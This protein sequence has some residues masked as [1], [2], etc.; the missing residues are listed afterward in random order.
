[1]ITEYILIGF[2]SFVVLAEQVLLSRLLAIKYWSCFASMVVSIAMLGFAASGTL[3]SLFSERNN[4]FNSYRGL[5]FAFIGL[6]IPLSVQVIYKTHCSPLAIFWEGR[7]IGIF[8]LNYIIMALP[9]LLTGLFLGSSYT[10]RDLSVKGVYF[11]SMI[12]SCIAV[13][14]VILL[15]NF[16]QPYRL[17]LL[18]SFPILFIAWLLERRFITRM[19]IIGLLI[20][21]F[22]QMFDV[23]EIPP[24]SEYKTMS[25]FMLLP[26]ARVEHTAWS[27]HGYTT[28]VASRFIRYAP[29]LSLNFIG[30]CPEQKAIFTDGESMRVIYSASHREYVRNILQFQLETLPYLLVSEPIVAMVDAGP[31]GVQNAIELG[32]QKIY[33]LERNPDIIKLVKHLNPF[34]GSV[35]SHPHVRLVYQTPRTFFER[36]HGEFDLVFLP[37]PPSG[38]ANLYGSSGHDADYMLTVEAFY[39]YFSSLSACGLIAV[40]ASLNLPP[41]EEMKL[42]TTACSALRLHGLN[43]AQHVFFVRSLRNCLLMVSRTPF[44]EEQI[45]S[46]ISFCKRN[47]FDIIYCYGIKR[48]ETN[49]FNILPDFTHFEMVRDFLHERPDVWHGQVFNLRPPTDNRPFFSHFFRW[50][51]LPLLVLAT[52]CNVAGQIGWG[53]VFLLI[54]LVQAIVIGLIFVLI[55]LLQYFIKYRRLLLKL[56]QTNL[57]FMAIGTGFMVFEIAVFQQIFRFVKS[58]IYAF[59]TGLVLILMF[60]GLGSLFA[61]RLR[62]NPRIKVGITA[63]ALFIHS[64]L[65]FLTI[66]WHNSALII[67]TVCSGICSA[68]LMGMPFPLGLEVL[69]QTNPK[70]IPLAWGLNGYMSVIA[71]L[72]ASIIAPCIGI[73]ELC[74]IAGISYIIASFCALQNPVSETVL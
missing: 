10:N 31:A 6:V 44:S 33:V 55:P 70:I 5:L 19:I 29:G 28:I 41:R 27:C 61:I 34:A 18:L 45:Q 58:Y 71:P 20:W 22:K 73:G 52:G 37:S 67:L 40:T 13:C 1:M 59:T 62:L 12:G 2:V 69:K 42:F 64:L 48:D 16:A 51:S 68:F 11:A 38:F 53:Y 60:S 54:T 24:M 36:A 8:V 39:D 43:P 63:A 72:V 50:H 4:R 23:P 3:L 14:V 47:G 46:A 32:A 21:S 17:L 66:R 25:K 15:L 7:Q 57:Y 65:W 30:E 26:D 49:R 56:W 9:F 74:I 35:Y